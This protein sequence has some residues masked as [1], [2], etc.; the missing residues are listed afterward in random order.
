MV[1]RRVILFRVRFPRELKSVLVRAQ[2]RVPVAL[3]SAALWSFCHKIGR[4]ALGRRSFEALRGV[5][6]R[7]LEPPLPGVC[8]WELGGN[9]AEL[10]ECPRGPLLDLDAF[11]PDE[12]E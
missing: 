7:L 10:A 8:A 12:T 6:G 3:K 9:V 5:R 1:C 4:C 2:A 11:A